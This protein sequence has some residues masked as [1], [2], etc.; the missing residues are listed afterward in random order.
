MNYHE[1]YNPNPHGKNVGDCAVRALSKALD[2]TWQE[3]KLLL[4]IYAFNMCDMETSDDV[5]GQI[6]YDNGFDDYKIKQG[7]ERCTLNEFCADHPKGCY[8][9]KLPSHV[10]CI[11]DGKFYDSWD[12]G[13]NIPIYYWTRCAGGECGVM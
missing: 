6:L 10:V 2:K 13:N 12:S 4:N 3:T 9:C 7:K 8:I 5:W 11:V 1:Y